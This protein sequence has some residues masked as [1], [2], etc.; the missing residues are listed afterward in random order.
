M[1]NNNLSG[2]SRVHSK[3]KAIIKELI[4][5][6]VINNL[7]NNPQIAEA[8]NKLSQEERQKA[9]AEIRTNPQYQKALK[10]TLELF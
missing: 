7:Y 1:E 6:N 3:A 8:L 9:I 5:L 10:A 4:E 2:T